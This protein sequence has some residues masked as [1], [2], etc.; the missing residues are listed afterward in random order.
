M[1]DEFDDAYATLEQD[2][3]Y[4][5]NEDLQDRSIRFG[6]NLADWK[7]GT[8]QMAKQAVEWWEWDWE[9]AYSPDESS[10]EFGIVNCESKFCGLIVTSMADSIQITRRSIR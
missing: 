1:L 7:P 6:L 2:A 5:L 3:G 9:Y 8:R 10:Q 4:I